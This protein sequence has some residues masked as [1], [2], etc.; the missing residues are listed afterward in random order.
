MNEWP[1]TYPWCK[2]PAV[3]NITVTFI[4]N[5]KAERRFVMQRCLDHAGIGID[6]KDIVSTENVVSGTER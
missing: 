1:C 3:W 4:D 6:V 5:N 2:K